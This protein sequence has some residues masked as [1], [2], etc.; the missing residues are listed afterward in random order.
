[1]MRTVEVFF[2]III[3]L[4]S[5]VIATQFAVLP[6]SRQAF[7]TNLRELSYSTL[8]TLDAQG[9]LSATIFQDYDDPAW[10]D[11]QK[12]L[13][14]SLP[15][16]VVYNLS[17]YDLSAN[18]EGTVTYQLEHSISDASFGADSDASSLLVAS[19]NVTFTQNPQKVGESTGQNITLYILN[20]DDA[21]GWWITG[22]TGQGL[23]TA[24]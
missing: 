5:F 3:L 6:S 11:L 14:A 12:A 21:N 17:V 7:G 16:N 1:M 10:G 4:G 9:S 19:P 24:F 15:P 13:S 2:V 23:A 18:L 22:Y 8:E 20:C